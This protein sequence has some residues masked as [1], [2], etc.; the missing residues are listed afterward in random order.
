MIK[1]QL[2]KKSPLRILEKSLNGGLGAGQMGVL[3][4]RKGVGKTACLVHIATDALLHGKNVLHISFS[5]DPK[6]IVRWYEQVFHEVAKS[7]KLDNVMEVHD[8]L[9]RRRLI[10]HFKKV[11]VDFA[12]IQAN[13]EQIKTG[14]SASPDLIIVDGYSF[15]D[16]LRERL[17][18]WRSFA[19]LIGV[20]LWFSATTQVE[21]TEADLASEINQ[22]ADL[23]EV[24]ILL[25]QQPEYI[26]LRLWKSPVAAQGQSLN[27]KLDPKT[28]L[29]S[30]HRA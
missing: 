19:A 5:D 23:F 22:L 20:P 2:I 10:L 17:E 13:I 14:L 6:H 24:I 7:Y 28:L 16:A 15:K 30:N 27:L 1:E 18:E 4:A 3:A 12:E 29:I 8:E 9:I 25:H 26:D 21:I 11:G